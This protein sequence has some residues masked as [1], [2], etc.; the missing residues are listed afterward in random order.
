MPYDAKSP[1]EY[2]GLLDDDRRKEKLLFVRKMIRSHAPEL[3][4]VIACKMPAFEAEE[5]VLALNA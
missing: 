5:L 2:L 4:E 1:K 3:K